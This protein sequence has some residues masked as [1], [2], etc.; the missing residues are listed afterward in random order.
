MGRSVLSMQSRERKVFDMDAPDFLPLGSV[1]QV[2]GNSKKLMVISRGL[3]VPQDGVQCYVDYGGCLYPEG[4]IGDVVFYFNHDDVEHVVHKG[5][6]DAED[7]E[8]LEALGKD[9][10]YVTLQKASPGPVTA[11]DIDRAVAESMVEA[12]AAAGRS[13]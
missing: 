9:L 11:E 4:L 2:K 7:G 10:G 8:L 12:D 3:T 1:V 13:D 5:Y 6:A